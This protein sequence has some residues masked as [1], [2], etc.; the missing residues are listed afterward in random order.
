[1]D[2]T[3]QTVTETLE[4]AITRRSVDRVMAKVGIA[5]RGRPMGRSLRAINPNR[6]E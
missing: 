1:V 4:V 6:N 2:P 3:H 5:F